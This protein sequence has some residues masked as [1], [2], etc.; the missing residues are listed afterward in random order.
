MGGYG[1]VRNE[2]GESFESV[3]KDGL[4]TLGT[5]VIVKSHFM[6]NIKMLSH[7]HEG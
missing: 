1:N 3:V 6:L 2:D 7:D 5:F 4:E